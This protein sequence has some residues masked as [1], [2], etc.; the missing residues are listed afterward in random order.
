MYIQHEKIPNAAA[1]NKAKTI[2]FTTM[3][4]NY[5]YKNDKKER[6]KMDNFSFSLCF[7]SYVVIFMPTAAYPLH[8]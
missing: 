1:E 8:N 6:I 5:S 4:V 3:L 7:G 2:V